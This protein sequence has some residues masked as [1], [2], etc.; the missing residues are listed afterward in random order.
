MNDGLRDLELRLRA[1]LAAPLPGPAAHASMLPAHRG[2]L[3]EPTA[4]LP[5]A[6]LMAI[7]AGKEGPTLLF[8]ERADAG[9]HGGQIAFPGGRKEDGDADLVT[10]AL[11]EAHEEIGLDPA[12]VQVLGLLSPL[13]I[14]VSGYFVQPVLGLVAEPPSL[15]A[16]P[17]E[18]A[19][20]VEV[21]LA[22][23]L[24]P[25]NRTSREIRVRG[26]SLTAPCYLFREILVWGATAM[27]LSELTSLLAKEST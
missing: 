23:L 19:S 15:R 17:A 8:I 22:L 16:N 20:I 4:Y 1:A 13:R 7:A 2:A 21:P 26:E 9:P 3:E 14:P 27:I 25:G 6:V 11:R 12:S 18:V 5:S 24:D 10:T